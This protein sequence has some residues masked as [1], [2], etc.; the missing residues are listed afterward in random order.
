ML[1]IGLIAASKVVAFLALALLLWWFCAAMA[2]ALNKNFIPTP[3]DEDLR[4]E[5][6]ITKT[7]TFNGTSKDMGSG[8]APGG[9]GMPVGAVVNVTACDRTSSDETYTFQLMESADNAT[10]TA[11]GPAVAVDV[12]GAT[13]TLGA[14]CVPGFLSQRYHRLTCTIA[15]TTPSITYEAWD[16]YN[17]L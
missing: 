1:L 12:S 6:S 15:G 13:V 16:N 11:A 4:I 14:I 8:F 5:A 2:P 9:I 3:Q 7:A 10:F 17:I